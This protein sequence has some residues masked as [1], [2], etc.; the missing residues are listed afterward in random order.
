MRSEGSEEVLNERSQHLLKLLVEH[1]IRDGQPVGSRTLARD[2]GMQLSAATIRN[3]MADLEELGFVTSPH[4][5]AGRIPTDKGYR[6]FVDTLLKFEPLEEEKVAEIQAQLGQ[7]PDDPKALI[8]VA[9]KLLSTVTMLAGVVTLPRQSHASLSQIEFLPLSDNRVLAIL[10]VNGRE[11]QNRILQLERTYSAE[12]LRRASN[13]LNRE[14]AGKELKQVRE[15]LLTQLKETRESLNQVMLDAIRLAQQ[16]VNVPSNEG[17][18]EYVI[19]G[20]TNLM[21]F[22]E[23]SNV[24]KLKRLFEAFTQQ[25]DI[26]HLLDQSL[27]ADGVQIFIGQESGYTIL[28]DCSVVTAPY[29]LDKEVVGVLGV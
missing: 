15:H 20:E 21:G 11:V 23:L 8:N 14:F 10:V 3:V 27:R 17:Q 16:V 9:S 12:E 18:M 22:A 4:T 13:Y 1:Y 6:F 29:T 2:M 24:E 26:L 5:S 19:A 25:R 28:D 7:H